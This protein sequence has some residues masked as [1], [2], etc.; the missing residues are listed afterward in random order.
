MGSFLSDVGQAARSIASN[1]YV[2]AGVGAFLLIGIILYI[3]VDS[4]LMPSLTR[5]DE[6]V[7]V[8]DV[9]NY[10]YD[11]AE[12]HLA[13]FDLQTEQVMER[14][15]P[16]APRD[17][18]IDQNPGP[19]SRVKPGRRVYLTVNSGQQAQVLI[20]RLRDLSIREARSRL[21]AVGLTA[22]E[23]RPDSIPSPFPNTIT[24]QTPAAGDSLS[25]GG[26]VDLWYST[27]LGSSYVSMP[28][29]VGMTIQEAEHALNGARLRFVVIG[30]EE[31]DADD[32][33]VIRVVRQ[34][35][36]PGTRVREGFEIR[37]FVGDDEEDV[38]EDDDPF[39][40]DI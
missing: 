25:P 14:F 30:A 7:E 19:N 12:R 8:P 33:A 28:D 35:R 27:G 10:S 22:G 40:F 38:Q 21:A 2:W 20:P 26:V 3:V 16:D 36:E 15:S 18:V 32:E 24:R 31:M 17:A 13:S 6:Y 39:A 1:P 11:D 29:L 5:H 37:L 4:L 9:R 34:S 23:L